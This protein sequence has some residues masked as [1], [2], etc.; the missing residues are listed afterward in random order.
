MLPSKEL[1]RQVPN[2]K[3]W[4]NYPPSCNKF[5]ADQ[6]TTQILH[7]LCE[8]VIDN[9]FLTQREYSQIEQ[10]AYDRYT[11][12]YSVF[13]IGHFFAMV[14]GLH[15]DNLTKDNMKLLLESNCTTHMLSNLDI[16]I[17]YPGV[18]YCEEDSTTYPCWIELRCKKCGKQAYVKKPK[19][20]MLCNYM[21]L[22]IYSVWSVHVYA[23]KESPANKWLY[24]KNE[25]WNVCSERHGKY[26]FDLKNNYKNDQK[27]MFTLSNVTNAYILHANIIRAV[28]DLIFLRTIDCLKAVMGRLESI[29]DHNNSDLSDTKQSAKEDGSESESLS[30]GKSSDNNSDEGQCGEESSMEELFVSK[31]IYGGDK[32][33]YTAAED[34]TDENH[35]DNTENKD[36]P[37][38]TKND[39]NANKN[40]ENRKEDN[41]KVTRTKKNKKKLLKRIKIRNLQRI[42]KNQ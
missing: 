18:A 15:F 2:P 22:V 36:K 42:I 20:T 28:C 32:S 38:S 27:R 29:I 10:L 26:L 16:R 6:F 39:T 31:N 24:P 25:S 3:N 12:D 35:T 14:I 34:L 37:E 30:N 21:L 23:I 40:L 11:R 33:D 41:K 7:I 13:S 19:N 8:P 17:Q 4:L 9:E 1:T 5:I